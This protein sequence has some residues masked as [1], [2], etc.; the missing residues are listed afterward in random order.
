[1]VQVRLANGHSLALFTMVLEGA[2]SKMAT[3]CVLGSH[4]SRAA[5]KGWMGGRSDM[6]KLA[7]IA[8]R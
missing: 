1:M 7:Q 6:G 2:S 8:L 3:R 5:C 4:P